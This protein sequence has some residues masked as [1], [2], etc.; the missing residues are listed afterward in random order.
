M[1]AWRTRLRRTRTSTTPARRSS[2]SRW[3]AGCRKRASASTSAPAASSPSRCAPASQPSRIALHGNNKS[4]RRARARHRRR[5]GPDRRRLLRRDR[6]AGRPDRRRRASRQRVLVR[7]TVGVEAHTHE[8][9]A[10]A[11]EDQKFGFSLASGAAEEA[12]ERVLALRGLELVGLHSH[13]GSQIFDTSGFEVSA[14]PGASACWRGSTTSTASSSPEL[15]LGGGLGIAYVPGDD[16][17]SPADIAAAAADHRRARVR[18]AHGLAAPRLAVEPGR[19]IVGSAGR[20]RCTRSARSSRRARRRAAPH[21]RL[22]RRR[23]E[24]Q[25]PHRAVRRRLHL[26]AGPRSRTAARC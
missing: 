12:V 4:R 24:R 13:I 2:P 1:R 22:R 26:H 8:F 6:P 17:M 21:V 5:G 20:S 9:I 14:A 19:A 7:V 3:P 11:H 15:D 16:P 10:T 25:H 23:H 18:S